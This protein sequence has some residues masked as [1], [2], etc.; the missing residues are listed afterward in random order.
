MKI[1]TSDSFVSGSNKDQCFIRKT[2]L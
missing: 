2:V 1:P